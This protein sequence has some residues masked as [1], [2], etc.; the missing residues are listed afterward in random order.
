MRSC[1]VVGCPHPALPQRT[2]I[3]D[4]QVELEV[5]V[6]VG[7]VLPGELWTDQVVITDEFVQNAGREGIADAAV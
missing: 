7:H 6:C 4:D 3:V 5:A 1:Q 2:V